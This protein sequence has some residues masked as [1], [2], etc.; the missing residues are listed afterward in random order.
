ML[1]DEIKKRITQAMKDRSPDKEVLRV[2]LGEIQT[3]EARAAKAFGDE[4][5]IAIVKKLLKSN[6]ETLAVTTD[7]EKKAG[8]ERENVVLESLLPAGLSVEQIVEALGPVADAVKGAGNDGQA[9][10][11]AMK[12]LKAQGARVDGKDV[13]AAVKKVRG[14]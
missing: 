9:T 10:G 2:A 14:G 13:T 12:H 11:I 6:Q 7:A 1:I 4:E 5:A 8:L 3:A